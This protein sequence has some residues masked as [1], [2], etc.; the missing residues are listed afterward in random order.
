MRMRLMRSINGRYRINGRYYSSGF[1]V[2]EHSTCMC[3]VVAFILVI[4]SA[5]LVVV[6]R[7]GC[8][9]GG[10]GCIGGGRVGGRE[11]VV[12]KECVYSVYSVYSMYSMYSVYSVLQCV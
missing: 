5:A 11:Q 1:R 8:I 4:A 3:L 2:I 6:S 7:W 12:S 9:E 10:Q